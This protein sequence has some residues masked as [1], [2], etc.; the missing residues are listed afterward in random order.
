MCYL[1]IHN[2]SYY[3]TQKIKK[4]VFFLKKLKS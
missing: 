2:A 4:Q 1:L 3:S